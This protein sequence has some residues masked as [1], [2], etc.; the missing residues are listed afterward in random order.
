MTFIKDL[1][2]KMGIGDDEP[3]NGDTKAGSTTG[4]EN[5]SGICCLDYSYENTEEG[6]SYSYRL[7]ED[8][9]ECIF[10]FS[11]MK[12]INCDTLKAVLDST[13]FERLDTLYRKFGLWKWEEFMMEEDT[14]EG[15]KNEFF[16]FMEFKDGGRMNAFGHNCGPENYPEFREKLE[17]LFGP[18]KERL[19]EEAGILE[20]VLAEREKMPSFGI[21]GNFTGHLE[22]AGEAADFVSVKTESANAP[23]AIFPTYL[24]ETE[25]PLRPVC[26]D[27]LH[28]YPFD[29]EKI[30]YPKDQD[31]LQI[32][33]ECA[34]VFRARWQAGKIIGLTPLAFGASNDCSIRRK[35]AKKISLKK[36]WGPCSK[37]FAKNTIS[38]YRFDQKSKIGNYRIASFLVRDGKVYDYGVDS[39]IKDY[40]YIYE[41]LIDWMIAKFNEQE[42]EGPAENIGAY[43]R[44]AGCPSYLLVSV[45]A[46]RYTKFGE[47]NYLKAGDRSV[48]VLYPE[49]AYKHDDIVNLVKDKKYDAK[50]ISVLD[51]LVCDE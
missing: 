33:P 48:V 24:P 15:K 14:G 29:G 12:Y 5:T 10:T 22:Q 32:E 34:I 25:K 1:L 40:S 42:N 31:K 26:P 37:G 36:N 6:V 39:A 44:E 51:Q 17:E 30:V 43:L 27:F 11:G 7:E 41:K 28:T 8:E 50:D 2:K 45:G 16:I 35:G 13:Y 20:D 23:K 9:G 46:T 18:V 3:E 38:L 47:S 19:L 21:A 4:V 49:Y